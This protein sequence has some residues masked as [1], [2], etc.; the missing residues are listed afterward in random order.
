MEKIMSSTEAL[1]FRIS[2]TFS[3]FVKTDLLR[4]RYPTKLIKISFQKHQF[5]TIIRFSMVIFSR[6]YYL[7]SYSYMLLYNL[8]KF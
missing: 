3:F 6:S 5:S 4:N 7:F 1:L 2:L 8:L